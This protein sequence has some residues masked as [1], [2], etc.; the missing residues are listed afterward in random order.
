MLALSKSRP[1][2][3]ALFL[4]FVGAPALPAQAIKP[5]QNIDAVIASSK[6]DTRTG[7]NLQLPPGGDWSVRWKESDFP[8]IKKVAENVYLYQAPHNSPGWITNSLI[9]VTTAGVVVLDGQGRVGEM[10]RLA[11]KVKKLTPQ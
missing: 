8:V 10:Q 4:L 1:W 11:D 9:V 6:Y 5:G 3:F 2:A 7:E